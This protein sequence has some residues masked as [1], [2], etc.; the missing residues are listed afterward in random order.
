MNLK[1]I[2]CLAASYPGGGEQNLLDYD[3]L[4]NM[5]YGGDYSAY[6][7]RTQGFIAVTPGSTIQL[8][9]LRVN[10]TNIRFYDESN[11]YQSAYTVSKN[12]DNTISFT[13][14]VPDDSYYIRPKWNRTTPLPVSEFIASNPVI[15][16]V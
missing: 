12:G 9:G 2:M 8:T 16:Y 3:D 1:Q 14:T 13:F 7:V 11:A 4:V 15:K 10:E 6:N 5:N